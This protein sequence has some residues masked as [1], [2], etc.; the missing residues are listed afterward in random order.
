MSNRRSTPDETFSSPPDTSFQ[1]RD[2]IPLPQPVVPE[3]GPIPYPDPLPAPLVPRPAARRTPKQ[4]RQSSPP[5]SLAPQEEP[6]DAPETSVLPKAPSTFVVRVGDQI[7]VFPKIELPTE[8]GPRCVA[9]TS[10]RQRCTVGIREA[11]DR[12]HR[13]R[14]WSIEGFGGQIRAL[15]PDVEDQRFI[16]QRCLMHLFSTEPDAVAPEW[17]I[18]DPKIHHEL[19]TTR[20]TS[21]WTPEGLRKSWDGPSSPGLEI[22]KEMQQLRNDLRRAFEARV[23]PPYPTALYRYFDVE[24][25]LLYVGITGDLA[26]REVSHIRDSSWMD[27]A[28]RA[29][30]ERYPTRRA[31]L[32]AE[33][34]AIEAEKPL[35]N[36]THNEWPGAARRLVEYLVEQGRTDLLSPAVSRG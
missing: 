34:D 6:R 14:L 36:V 9:E 23:H 10:E 35:F 7:L 26:V 20:W 33:R 28:A 18:F 21:T 22:F 25:H 2:E 17:E 29:T 16:Q 5:P 24:G 8:A 3:P 11:E 30:I 31:A 1:K 13:T 32:D 27:F 15:E 12:P 19:V 4:R